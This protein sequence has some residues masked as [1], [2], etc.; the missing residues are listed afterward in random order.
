MFRLIQPDRLAV[1]IWCVLAS[2]LMLTSA[3]PARAGVTNPKIS[4]LGQPRIVW[5]DDTED[6]DRKRP[7]LDIGE[8]EIIYDDYLNPYAS[9]YFTLAIAEEGLELEEGYFTLF[10]GL[11]GDVA[12]RGGQF[13]VPFGR[14]NPTHP[15]A[16]P[17]A[18]P[19]EVVSSYLPGEEAFIEPGVQLSRR[20][21]IVGDTSVQVEVDWLQ[22]NS[23]RLE[24]EADESDGS[25]P[26]NAGGD[27]GAELTRPAF[28]GRLSGFGMLGERSALE[29]GFS[30]AGGTNNV[31][32]GTR[33]YAYGADAKAK[34]WTSPQAYLVLQ[35]ELLSLSREDA[36]WENGG[37]VANDVDA[38]GG[39]VFADYNW[40]SRYNVGAS[41][42]VFEAPEAEGPTTR[43][44]GLF[45]G[46][47]LME[48]TTAIRLDWKHLDPEEGD[49]AN[50]LTLRVIYS[51]GPH[52]AHQF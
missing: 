50:T 15:H 35:G 29:V 1:S 21:P 16:L 3:L 37:Y 47:A 20:F 43:G 24:R 40:A 42:E 32:A 34:L 39:Y 18:E 41:F 8:T 12:L 52:K 30:A 48:E 49:G 11:P 23:F 26:L 31:D 46:I 27:D 5:T 6:P 36:G 45:G 25:D 7:V 13:R 9:G 33:T 10:R 17:F 38:V 44:L 51:M 14:I 22:G 4:I 19:F 2:V 28:F